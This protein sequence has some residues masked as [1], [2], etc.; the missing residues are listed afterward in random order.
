[1]KQKVKTGVLLITA[2]SMAA[3]ARA[4]SYSMTQIG[5]E[6]FFENKTIVYNI[7]N[8]G[9]MVGSTPAQTAPVAFIYDQGN[10]ATLGTLPGYSASFGYNINNHGDVA[11]VAGY[12]SANGPRA[13]LYSGGNM[14]GLG[15]LGGN[16]SEVAGINDARQVA[17]YAELP[18]GT[19]RA[20]VYQ[21]G[22]MTNLGTLHADDRSSLATDINNRGQVVGYVTTATGV[23]RP[24]L[25]SN[26]TLSDLG[27]FQ[28]GLSVAATAINDAGQVTGNMTLSGGG[29]R[30]FIYAGGAITDLGTLSSGTVSGASDINLAGHV[31][32]TSNMGDPSGSDFHAFLYKDGVMLDLNDLI[33]PGLDWTL[34][35]AAAINDAGQIICMAR[36][37]GFQ[38]ASFLL[39]PI[40]E[41]ATLG[42]LAS[43]LACMTRQRRV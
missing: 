42:I 3:T 9:Q 22:V 43:C 12:Y 17:G 23:W 15:T 8:R 2:A 33:D 4:A 14:V 20:F 16:R 41:P 36:N 37:S 18:D 13:F 7:N 1:M 38:E 21:D 5:V 6:G 30:A 35:G 10:L 27:S 19:A 32:G 24:F 26:G 31:V 11:G 25:Y 29:Q 28:D 39:T 34:T 40:P